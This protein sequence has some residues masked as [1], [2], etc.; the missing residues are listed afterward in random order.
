MAI[1]L[2]DFEQQIDPAILKRGH[3]YFKKGYV[4]YVED[5]GHGDYEAAVEGSDTYTVSLH[6]EGDEVTDYECDCPYDWGPVCKHVAAVLFYLQKD[7]SETDMP[8]Q[9]GRRDKPKRESESAQF[10]KLLKLLALEELKSFLSEACTKD[11]SLRR[12]FIAKYISRLYP[13]SKELY[14]QQVGKLVKTFSDRYGFVGYHEA[15]ELGSAVYEMIEEARHCVATGKNQK[16]LYMS[17][18]IIEGMFNTIENADDSNGE[19]S[20]CLEEAF[21]VLSEL[22]D[23]DPDEPLHNEMFSWLIRHYEAGSMK[24]W[25]WHADLMRVAIS[26]VKTEEEKKH[27]QTALEQVRP[28]GEDWDWNYRTAQNLRL[29][30]IRRTEDETAA[31]RFME[32]NVDNSDFRKELIEHAL[33]EKDYARAERLAKEGVRKDDKNA[34]GLAEDWRDYLL[35]VYQAT[36]HTEK[37]I[38]LARHFFVNGGGRHQP[39]EYY[40]KLLKSLIPQAQWRQYV[41]G[42]IADING[43]SRWNEPYNRVAQIYIWEKDWD[44]LFELLRKSPSFSRVEE[45]EK[46]LAPDR[47]GELATMYRQLII[48]YMP[49]HIGR[50]HY[51]TVCKYIRRMAKLGHEPMALELMELLRTQYRNRRALLEELAHVF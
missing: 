33:H 44:K 30:L 1:K 21:G 45:A 12:L 2:G 10:E 47:S 48:D 49:D 42:L 6:I 26:M 16:A 19:I 34:P 51:L 15:S 37:I 14:M 17:E 3:E 7:L 40:Y 11:K 28:N 27:I 39:N 46:Y 41:E 4:T 5:L 8:L 9:E 43:K 13:E 36:H 38:G 18:A 29:Q 24:G 35:Q 32:S 22:A 50:N 20:G 25:D 31:M 23:T